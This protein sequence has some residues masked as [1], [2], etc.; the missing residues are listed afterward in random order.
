MS[1]T[2]RGD[3]GRSAIRPERRGAFGHSFKREDWLGRDAM[4]GIHEQEDAP[5]PSG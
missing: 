3:V 4:E 2:P 5:L 1:D